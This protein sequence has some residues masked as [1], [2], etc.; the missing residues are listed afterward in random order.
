M[1]FWQDVPFNERVNLFDFSHIMYLIT[2]VVVVA[3][4][5]THLDWIKTNWS[6][7]RKVMIGVSLVQ[8]A[9]LYSW[10]F[11]ELGF[12]LEAGLPIH[13]CRMATFLGLYFLFTE[14]TRVFHALYY[15]SAFA[16]VAILYPVNVHPIYTHAIGWSYQISHLMILLVWIVGVYQYGYRPTYKVLNWAILWF[17]LITLVV[18]RFNYWVGDGEYLYLRS[19]VNRPFFKS[20]PDLLW[21]AF[22]I[23]LSYAVMWPMTWMFQPKKGTRREL[24]PARR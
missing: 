21:I 22:T 2:V 23:G 6:M 20:W 8:V 17:F 4:F 19:D 14:D 3:W 16:I 7:V 15:M 13:L 18:W 9:V 5:A 12:S 11:L 24:G 10:S 1:A